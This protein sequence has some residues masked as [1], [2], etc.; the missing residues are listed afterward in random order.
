MGLRI[1][2][3]NTLQIGDYVHNPHSVEP[4]RVQRIS[5]TYEQWGKGEQWERD[6]DDYKDGEYVNAI[7][8]KLVSD[9]WAVVDLENDHWCYGDQ[10]RP[11]TPE[12]AAQLEAD[13]LAALMADDR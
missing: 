5:L 7:N 13:E 1:L 10:I 11:V 4:S 12:E 6:G 9:G 3:P 2:S 8:W